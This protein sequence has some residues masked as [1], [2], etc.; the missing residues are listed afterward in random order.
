MNNILLTGIGLL[1]L[2]C[3][4]E[5]ANAARHRSQ[6]HQASAVQQ[7]WAASGV[8][9]E[10]V[11]SDS[12]AAQAGVQAGDVVIAV[13]G[14]PIARWE[15]MDPILSASGG[16]SLTIDIVRGGRRLRF[17]AAPRLTT[18]MNSFGR[19]RELGLGHYRGP[20]WGGHDS[21]TDVIIIPIPPDPIPPPFMPPP[22]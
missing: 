5:L 9:V 22:Q 6:G 19:V 18:R 3:N 12:A 11:E 15:D 8:Q 16:R 2:N 13:G 10:F 4:V 14:R 7:Q 1:T 20:I 21:S 17:S